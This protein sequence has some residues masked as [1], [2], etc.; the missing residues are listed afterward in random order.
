M[1]WFNYGYTHA[2][3]VAYDE[4]GFVTDRGYAP[5][6]G[7]FVPSVRVRPAEEMTL[8]EFYLRHAESLK[9]TQRFLLQQ[10]RDEHQYEY[11]RTGEQMERDYYEQLEQAREDPRYPDRYGWDQYA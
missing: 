2:R 8:E 4:L 1:A 7:T 3:L 5:G 10:E 11:D 9:N 6:S